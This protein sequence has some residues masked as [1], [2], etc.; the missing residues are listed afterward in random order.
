MLN[1]IKW[2]LAGVLIPVVVVILT[3]YLN[4]RELK[5]E[6]EYTYEGPITTALGTSYSLTITNTG[7]QIQEDIEVWLPTSLLT[8]NSR[9]IE[10]KL[11][12]TVHKIK[13]SS[14]IQVSNPQVKFEE[15]VDKDYKLL[16]FKSL[17]P[18]ENITFSV[19]SLGRL[20]S[21]HSEYSLEQLR[22][23][24]KQSVAKVIKKDDQL[25]KVYQ[26]FT[27]FFIILIVG[28]IIVG[29]IFDFFYPK[30]KKIRMYEEEIRKLRGP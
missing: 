22:V 21:I 25:F 18:S 1:N 9:E 15:I 20:T 8:L 17:R 23:V 5:Y 4:Q 6:L 16:K 11:D 10:L 30:D 13:D 28:L 12:S 29:I 27:Y 2:L 24:S 19:L 3:W 26:A 14:L 7:K